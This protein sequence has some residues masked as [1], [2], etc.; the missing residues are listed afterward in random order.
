MIKHLK[1]LLFLVAVLL[2]GVSYANI[3]ITPF[4]VELDAASNKRVKS[5]KVI[6]TTNDA[7]TYRVRVVNYVQKDDG[8]FAQV[9]GKADPDAN[10]AEPYLTFSPRQFTLEP[11]KAQTV[12]VGRKAV[13]NLKDGEYVSHLLVQEAK[14]P[15]PMPKANADSNALT[16]DIQALYGITIPVILTK[17][18]LTSITEIVGLKKNVEKDTAKLDVSL[19]RKGT[20]SSWGSVT[21]IDNKGD[22]VGEL[23]NIR[24][25]LSAKNREVSVPLN[26][27]PQELSGKTL[28]VIFNDNYAKKDV[29]EK[30]ISF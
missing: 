29:A 10:F 23:K 7:Q 2:P 4:L 18:D 24:I 25:Y 22:K 13:P 30:T 3:S 1:K 6:N 17:G 14:K 15:T 11:K 21:V 9:E 5:V 19:A 16:I 26:K 12:N 28:K 8:S 20:K 27:T